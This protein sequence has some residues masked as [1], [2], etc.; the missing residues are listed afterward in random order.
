MRDSFPR[1]AAE[2]GKTG[3]A[4]QTL[5]ALVLGIAVSATALAADGDLD[6]GFGTGGAVELEF[7]SPPVPSYTSA[8]RVVAQSDGSILVLANISSA[9]GDSTQLGGISKLQAN[10]AFD[11]TFGVGGKALIGSEL[12][13][14]MP[15]DMKV[16]AGGK[17][18]VVG[19]SYPILF[20]TRLNADGSPDLGFGTD[21]FA[22]A[23]LGNV[24]R[25][26]HLAVQSD[27]KLVVFTTRYAGAN[28]TEIVLLRYEVNGVLDPSFGIDGVAGSGLMGPNYEPRAV[29]LQND[30]A[31]LAAFARRA[32]SNPLESRQSKIVARFTPAGALDPS[33]NGTGQVDVSL[34]SYVYD[35]ATSLAVLPGGKILVAGYSQDAK[36]LG[37]T[38]IL[39]SGLPDTTFGT[40]GRA[41]APGVQIADSPYGMAVLSDGRF[42]TVSGPSYPTYPDSMAGITRFV[43]DGR[44][45]PNFRG[46]GRL[47]EGTLLSGA[48]G[49]AI[50]DGRKLLA[51][52]WKMNGLG[53]KAV[54]LRFEGPA[55]SEAVAGSTAISVQEGASVDL[56]AIVFAES[57]T[58]TVTFRLG[59]ADITGC[60][61]VALVAGAA[62]C[63]GQALPAGANAITVV[64][65]GDANN[66][67][68]TSPVYTQYVLSSGGDVDGDGV[69]DLIE[70]AES[71]NP[72][73]KDND[74]FPATA[75]S[76][77]LFAMQQYRDFLGREGEEAGIAGWANAVSSGAWRQAQV[78]DAFQSSTEFTGFVPPVV[79][80]YFATFQRVPDYAGLLQNVG[81]LRGATLT[82]TQLAD[83]FAA[84]PEFMALYGPLDDTQFVTRLYNNVLGRA[85]DTAGLNGWVSLLAG[86][87][88]RGRVLLG[89]S[90]SAEYQA[91]MAN[92]VF[93][94][95]MYTQMLRRSPDSPGFIA[96]VGY[97]DSGTRAR[98][99]VING[100][101]LST[102]YH[103]RFLP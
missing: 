13:P 82:L 32:S 17:I 53:S 64:Y 57:P 54:V 21:G 58:G 37:V 48:Q 19:V 23:T 96:W 40:A 4:A 95:V 28:F 60:V 18:V 50:Q 94:T 35:S 100:F 34:P 84:S 102:E 97:L 22:F 43:P 25:E 36:A 27:G 74:I 29:A 47:Y 66:P 85:P 44:L 68:A 81:L 92:E 24:V 80:L 86:G 63:T 14:L 73:V 1:R 75:R 90:D 93:V 30:G 5:A 39:P 10:G 16:V 99:Q 26:P 12:R 79:R 31:I 55:A 46:T 71:L 61:G 41:Y 51:V 65:S 9:T 45:D 38:R 76:A 77:R 70:A 91:L 20:V 103:G 69:P 56:D 15:T 33:F 59:G 2:G 3:R 87:Y 42:V 8:L 49:V 7:L 62:S 67:P 89:F 88:T 101:F 83:A 11:T 6:A 98:E 52:G 78:I 72:V